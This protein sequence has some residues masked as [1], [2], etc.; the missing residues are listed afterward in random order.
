MTVVDALPVLCFCASIFLVTRLYSSKVFLLGAAF[1]VLAG[2]GKVA[3]KLVLAMAEKD[4]QLLFKQFRL[5]MPVGGV[6]MLASLVVDRPDFAS[7]WKNVSSF[8]C[9]WLFIAAVVLFVLL[10]VLAEM[11]DPNSVAANWVEQVVNLLAQLCI[12]VVVVIIWYGA[13][14]YSADVEEYLQSTDSVTVEEISEGLYFH[15]QDNDVAL[16]FYPGAKVEYSAYAPLMQLLAAEGVDCFLMEMPYNMAFFGINKATEL[17]ESYDYDSWYLG[18]HSLGGAV[19]AYCATDCADS[20]DGI[21]LLASYST[22]DLDDL[23]V[24]ALYGS[25][26]GVLN[27]TKLDSNCSSNYLEIC[28]EGGN[29]AQFGSY[30]EQDGDNAATITA[31]EQWQQT[32]EAIIDF[33]ASSNVDK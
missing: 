31:E 2:L 17:M 1:C 18:G 33:I 24:L 30:G 9:N 21:I 3:W 22:C 16:V 10:G 7:L 19:A 13:S 28:I 14:Y 8:P 11:M 20:L 4:V 15:G 5:T 25:E 27:R 12:L 6:L 29:H 23:P 32:C 26:D